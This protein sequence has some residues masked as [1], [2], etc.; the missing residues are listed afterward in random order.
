MIVFVTD[1]QYKMSLSLLQDLV[2]EGMEV[3][4]CHSNASMA[5]LGFGIRG[6][7]E[8]HSLPDAQKDSKGYLDALFALLL[9]CKSK[10]GEKPVLLPVGA[11]TLALLVEQEARER[12][13]P[14]CHFLLPTS[15][16]LDLLNSKEKMADIALELGVPVPQACTADSED[17]PLVVKP[18]C[19]EKL[20]LKAWE[21]YVIAKNPSELQ[22]AVQKYQDLSGE[23]PLIQQCISGEGY[24]CSVLA[25]GGNVKQMIT[26]RRLREYPIGGGPSS[27]CISVSEPKLE[28]YTKTLVKKLNFSGIAMFEYK[29]CDSQGFY[30]LEVNPRV[31][32]SYPLT[33][34]S[35]SSFSVDWAKASVQPDKIK[36]IPPVVGKKMQYLPSD[37][38]AFLSY[39]KAGRWG[40][41][42]AALGDLLNPFVPDGA[43][44]WAQPQS[45]A[46]YLLSVLKKGGR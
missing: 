7:A 38:M 3:H 1:I 25:V 36:G 2:A 35:G 23:M 16:E 28:E 32:G 31:W 39:S 9:D 33:R 45:S 37:T 11:V 34:I 5:A 30:F 42:F 21:R 46:G 22:Q 29:G 43:I 14:V 41:A 40:E 10:L 20:G 44:S 19:G 15:E 8:R 4:A 13:A 27:A 17:F 26:H 18:S 12:F 6:L 24:G